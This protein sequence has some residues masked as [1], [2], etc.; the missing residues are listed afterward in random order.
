MKRL[1]ALLA[2]VFAIPARCQVGESTP[3]W[4]AFDMPGLEAA[5]GTPVDLSALNAE[6]AGKHG[7]LRV[8][9]GHFVDGQGTRVRLIGS[10]IT[11]DS[12]FME[13]ETADRLAKRLRQWGFN[14]LRLH[15]MDFNRGG[16]IW[17]DD[18]TGTLS[19]EQLQRLDHLIAACTKNGIYID[20]NLHV[21]R[22]YPDQPTIPGSRA[23]RFGKTLDRWYDPYIAMI[24]AYA[25][26][27]LDRR[28]TV[29]GIRWA[30]DPGIGVIEINNE[31]TL[32]REIR[33]EYRQLPDPWKSA[34]LAKWNAWLKAK[35]G[36]TAALRKTWD[37]G[38]QP[39]GE[40][41]LGSA[42]KIEKAGTAEAT[43]TETD[44]VWR[45][46][47]TKAGTA[48]WHLQMQYPDLRLPPG[49]Y[50]FSF[51]ARS[52]TGNTLSHNLMLNQ[53]PWTTVGLRATL[54]LT[55]EWQ[56]FTITTPVIAPPVDGPL[57]LNF[58]L[59]NK[60]GEVEFADFSLRTGG[61][62]GLPKNQTFA[63]GIGIPDD[64][65]TDE[66]TNDWYAFLIDT[67]MATAKRIVTFLK[68][69][70]GCRAPIADTQVT[71][72]GAGGIRR[73]SEICDY[74]DI[75]GYWE[76]PHYARSD[77]GWVTGFRIP[78][79]TQV[80]SP[81]AAALGNLAC[82]RVAGLPLSVS[83][84]NTPA[85]NDHGA[86]L[87]PLL[88][89][90]AALQDWDALYSYTYRDF[91]KSYE[92]TRIRGHFH[93]IGRADLLVHIPASVHL[94][95]LG[96]LQPATQR[97]TLV[98]PLDQTA[99][100]TRTNYWLSGLWTKLGMELGSAWF[101]RIE[102]KTK[103]S[104]EPEVL[105]PMQLPEGGCSDGPVTWFPKDEKG[106][107]LSLNVPS[108]RLLIG[109]VGGR[110]FKVGDIGLAVAKRP[111]PGDLPAYACI[112]LTA[113][114]DQ[115]VAQSRRLLLAASAR[116]E[117]TNMQWNEDRTSLVGKDA[118]GGNS[119]V[120]EAVPL[121]LDLPGA[122]YRATALDAQGR[123][124]KPVQVD[125]NRLQLRAEDQT[126][127]VLIER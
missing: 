17:E 97:T 73:E 82:N 38:V 110:Q 103:P 94:F 31:N 62:K 24:E 90:M 106:P 49:R 72:G 89:A 6:P 64:D 124:G 60:V 116:T 80:A 126:L 125:G 71:Y 67:E 108:V 1:L 111:W 93:L 118:W 30:D 12:C 34:F 120:S 27:L 41:L 43:L 84:Y 56:T 119:T 104:G 47:A 45:W 79:T 23:F 10:N 102:V 122:A 25:R 112:S 58:S 33:P 16:S 127:W 114:D 123:P 29:T 4:F 44:G 5:S 117:N 19:E 53:A 113:L 48:F 85:P 99:E 22:A 68:K 87:F 21:G 86:E 9:D 115:P 81:S 59:N 55:P 18:K 7:F 105:D 70:L 95:R 51:R 77:K 50:T 8:V 83:E 121:T 63:T 37:R 98:L 109:H 69:D 26:G 65:V 13:P 46:S 66:V 36:T 76:H 28:S 74:I 57:R 3:G 96:A 2:I 100:L 54:K 35:Y 32:I 101:R 52:R 15:F 61:G 92:D 14:C 39:L 75:H 42:W 107:W 91:G 40:N 88:T 78:N 20:L 11:G